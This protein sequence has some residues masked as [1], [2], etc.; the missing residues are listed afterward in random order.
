V[1][2]VRRAIVAGDL[3]MPNPGDFFGKS[4]GLVDAFGNPP[5]ATTPDGRSIDRL[6]TTP[7]LAA[8]DVEVVKLPGADHYPVVCR[9]D[10]RPPEE[11][12]I[13]RVRQQDLTRPWSRPGSADRGLTR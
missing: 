9:L 12:S 13:G 6:F 10:R 8:R 3:N 4:L 2:G 7:D 5:P 1:R 11:P